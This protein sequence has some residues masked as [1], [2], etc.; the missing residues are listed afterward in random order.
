[1]NY[2]ERVRPEDFDVAELWQA[3]REGSLFIVKTVKLADCESAI[4]NVRAYVQRIGSFVTPPFR[5]SIDAL[6]DDIFSCDELM[7]LLIPRKKHEEITQEN[8]SLTW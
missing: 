3:A 1:M 8:A 7:A 6:W 2:L 4:K 5:A